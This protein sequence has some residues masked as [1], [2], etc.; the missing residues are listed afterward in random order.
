[1]ILLHPAACA[2]GPDPVGRALARG[3]SVR[4]EHAWFPEGRLWYFDPFAWQ[5]LFAIAV[6][7]GLDPY[8]RT[9]RLA[10]GDGCPRRARRSRSSPPSSSLSWSLHEAVNRIPQFIVLPETW[11]DKTMLPPARLL[12]VLALAVLVG[13]SCRAERAS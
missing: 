8:Q 1:M 10:P 12:S 5:F 2:S 6:S 11:F 4:L 13:P 3:E 9:R 7:L